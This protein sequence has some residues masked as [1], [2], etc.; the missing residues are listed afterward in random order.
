MEI[1]RIIEVLQFTTYWNLTTKPII[2]RIK[3]LQLQCRNLNRN[4][5]IDLAVVKIQ[6]NQALGEHHLGQ[7]KLQQ[8]PQTS[9]R[10]VYCCSICKPRTNHLRVCSSTS[11][12]KWSPFEQ[13]RLGLDGLVGCERCTGIVPWENYRKSRGFVPWFVTVQAKSIEVWK[14]WKS[15]E[16]GIDPN[17][18]L[19]ERSR[20]ARF[21]S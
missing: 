18:L 10:S 9:P 20:K 19:N 11:Q 12:C 8:F 1:S 21:L 16:G 4:A 5:S 13:T 14:L 15:I 17:R 6:S 7:I 3:E 2:T